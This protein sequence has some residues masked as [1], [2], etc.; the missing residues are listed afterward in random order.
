MSH[1][2]NDLI[3]GKLASLL[4]GQGLRLKQ[5]GRI[6]ADRLDRRIAFHPN[7]IWKA[8]KRYKAERGR[9]C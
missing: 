6:L 9:D 3:D 1:P 5:I 4:Q 2:Q 8:I 7:S